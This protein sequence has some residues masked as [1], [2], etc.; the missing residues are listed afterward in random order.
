MQGIRNLPLQAWAAGGILR[1]RA[2]LGEL[3]RGFLVSVRG[4]ATAGAGYTVPDLSTSYPRGLLAQVRVITDL[5]TKFQCSGLLTSLMNEYDGH[6]VDFSDPLIRVTAGAGAYLVNHQFSVRFNPDDLKSIT[7]TLN[8]DLDSSPFGNCEV[9]ITCG[10][11]TDIASA[12]VTFAGNVHVTQI[13]DVMPK[14]PNTDAGVRERAAF[15]NKLRQIL[16]IGQLQAIA[17]AGQLIFNLPREGALRRIIFLARGSASPF[18]LGTQAA[19]LVTDV[20]LRLNGGENIP[21]ISTLID[22]NSISRQRGGMDNGLTGWGIAID[23]DEEGFG[24]ML[25]SLEKTESTLVVTCAAACTVE[26][27]PEIVTKQ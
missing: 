1:F 14:F 9:E 5:G 24:L 6:E 7:S 23:F 11:N 10:V 25:P 16:R 3:I 18:N 12:N 19:P 17:G 22:L 15:R 21:C 20:Q 27:V 4:T 13:T 26:M 8:Y 2:N